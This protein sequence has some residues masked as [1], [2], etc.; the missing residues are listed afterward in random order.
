MLY[1]GPHLSIAD[2]YAKAVLSAQTIG[3]NT[4]QFFSRNPRGSRFRKED[5]KDTAKFNLFRE[6]FAFGPLQAHAPYTLNLAASD[7]RVY[8]FGKTVI[9]EDVRR[10]DALGIDYL[11]LHPGSHTGSGIEEGLAHIAEALIPAVEG[12]G[13]IMVLLE[14][15]PGSGTEVG[16]TFLE[17][18]RLLESVGHKDRLGVCMDTCHV[19]AAGYDVRDDLD[20]VLSEF[21]RIIG[22]DRLKSVHLNDSMGTLGSRRDRH[23]PLGEGEIG[24]EAILNLLEHPS[25]QNLPFYTETP[26]DD[27]EHRKELAMIR[28]LLAERREA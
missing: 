11:V 2:G 14:T 28:R 8:E 9:A 23:L 16:S 15:M 22:I 19:F 18:S 13:H 12:A 1:I 3:A 7:E 27:E 6:Q 4:F 21:D 24:M 25:L 20:G 5:E 26:L 17:L 10:M